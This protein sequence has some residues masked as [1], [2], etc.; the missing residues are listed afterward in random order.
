[1]HWLSAAATSAA[2]DRP[3]HNIAQ[4]RAD[5]SIRA[6][7]LAGLRRQDDRQMRRNLVNAAAISTTTWS[8]RN[9]DDQR[10]SNRS[11]APGTR[12]RQRRPR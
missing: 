12:P 7:L 11:A 1:M 10:V 8:I 2:I 5:Q 3:V 6:N 4:S 9:A